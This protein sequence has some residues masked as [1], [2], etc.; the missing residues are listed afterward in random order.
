[1]ADTNPDRPKRKISPLVFLPPLIF[2]GFAVMAY[3][4]LQRG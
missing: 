1:M 3:F 2:L 4:G